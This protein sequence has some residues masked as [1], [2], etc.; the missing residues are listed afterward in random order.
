LGIGA[1]FGEIALIDS[2]PRNATIRAREYCDLY[3]LDKESFDEVIKE[4][5]EFY[6]KIKEMAKKRREEHRLKVLNQTK[7]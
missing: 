2:A 5:P 1:Y 6:E 4:Y 7:N 3:S